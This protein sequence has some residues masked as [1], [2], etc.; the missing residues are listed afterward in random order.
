MRISKATA[1]RIREIADRLGYVPNE[2]ARR[3]RSQRSGAVGVIFANLVDEWPGHVAVG[4]RAGFDQSDCIPVLTF[5][6]SDPVTERR[7]I[8]RLLGQGA[9]AIVCVP[10]G[11]TDNYRLVLD[12]GIP[13][14]MLGDAPSGLPEASSVSW[15]VRPAA[16]LATEHLLEHGRRRI[17]FLGAGSPRPGSSDSR[18]EGY[19]EGLADAGIAP[20]SKF[21]RWANLADPPSVQLALREILSLPAHQRP[22]AML[23]SHDTIALHALSVLDGAGLR[24]P[25]DV[26]L[27]TLGSNGMLA[28]PRIS[29]STILE[30]V[31]EM[32]KAAAEV[33]LELIKNPQAGPIHRRVAGNEIQRRGST[34]R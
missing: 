27:I 12:R 15:D 6:S 30:P 10:L 31:E 4:A 11:Q 16:R 21:T 8:Q 9:E 29:I 26:A 18:Q 1:G 7:E 25:E 3:L 34:R 23:C 33:V 24:V 19:L 2:A 5:H 20:L 13:L 17:A 28:H 32:G 14:V 22:N